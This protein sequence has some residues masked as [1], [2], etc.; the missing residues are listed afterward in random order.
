MCCFVAAPCFPKKSSESVQPKQSRQL[1]LPRWGTM[2]PWSLAG[3]GAG[4][5]NLQIRMGGFLKRKHA[6][7]DL[8]HLLHEMFPSHALDTVFFVFFSELTLNQKR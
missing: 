1:H 3:G 4:D 2:L 6:T 8:T 7:L 5:P